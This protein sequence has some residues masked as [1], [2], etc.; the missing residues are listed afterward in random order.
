MSSR[1]LRIV[2]LGFALAFASFPCFA[3]E[4]PDEKVWRAVV[5]PDGSRALCSYYDDKIGLFDLA[6]GELIGLGKGNKDCAFGLAFSPD[7]TMAASSDV[8]KTVIIW[9]LATMKKKAAIKTSDEAY[10][11]AFSPDGK[12]LAVVV[13]GGGEVYEV[14][15]N[16]KKVG[17]FPYWSQE[18]RLNV[19]Q[20]DFGDQQIFK[21]IGFNGDASMIIA[22]KRFFARAHLRVG[23]A[24][25]E[26][27]VKGA[28]AF[29]RFLGDSPDTFA[30][31]R[32][33]EKDGARQVSSMT[34][35]SMA[36][37]SSVGSS[38]TFELVAGRA[39]DVGASPS[40]AFVWFLM[41]GDDGAYRLE[42]FRKD[43]AVPVASV[44]VPER[45]RCAGISEKDSVMWYLDGATKAL[46]KVNL[47]D[48]AVAGSVKLNEM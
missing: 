45:T 12:Y 35:H 6:T 11:L 15:A 36:D 30:M 26:Y 43:V 37:G 22:A 10:S 42:A 48:G 14:G 32:E 34:L 1:I 18:E 3:L 24:K 21:D 40:G 39:E 9:D 4:L 7:M 33:P 16:P 29:A 47:A 25:A 2:A 23:V 31:I 13:K 28:Y 44:A 38:A 27:R 41:K 20:F 17:S 5:S 46:T 19:E 8:K